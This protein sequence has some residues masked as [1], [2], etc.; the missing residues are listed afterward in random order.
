[1][2]PARAARSGT[3]RQ[4]GRS[5]NAGATT[6]RGTMAMS[7]KQRRGGLGRG[8][9]ALIPTSAPPAGLPPTTVP[10]GSADAPNS[11]IVTGPANA[12]APA[13]VPGAS[14]AELP[15]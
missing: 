6:G 15:V 12:Y 1:M 9:G 7:S 13:P 3:P 11:Y 4:R 5:P 14:F 2:T 10:D 8:L